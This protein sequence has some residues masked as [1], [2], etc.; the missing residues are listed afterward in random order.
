M[1]EATTLVVSLPKAGKCRLLC[2]FI[3]PLHRGESEFLGQQLFAPCPPVLI[4]GSD[5]DEGDWAECLHL[6]GLLL[7]G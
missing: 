4:V 3:G 1:K 7:D 6:A 5:Q 2:Q